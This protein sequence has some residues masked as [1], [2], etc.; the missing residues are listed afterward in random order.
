MAKWRTSASASYAAPRHGFPLLLISR[1]W[2]YIRHIQFTIQLFLTVSTF[3]P[4]WQSPGIGY[5]SVAADDALSPICEYIKVAVEVNGMDSMLTLPGETPREYLEYGQ[6]M[7]TRVQIGGEG[8]MVGRTALD[9]LTGDFLESHGLQGESSE[10]RKE[11]IASVLGCYAQ[12]PACHGPFALSEDYGRIDSADT[13]VADVQIGNKCFAG[14]KV[15][16]GGNYTETALDFV[17]R[18]GWNSGAG[19]RDALCVAN[20]IACSVHSAERQQREDLVKKSDLVTSDSGHRRK[21]E[22]ID[23][24][25]TYTSLCEGQHC[26]IRRVCWTGSE[27]LMKLDELHEAPMKK[28]W[29]TNLLKHPGLGG[30]AIATYK[31]TGLVE[32]ELRARR[33]ETL[34]W[35]KPPIVESRTEIIFQTHV[36]TTPLLPNCLRLLCPSLTH[37]SLFFFGMNPRFHMSQRIFSLYSV[38]LI[39]ATRQLL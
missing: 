16:R 19:C 27:W 4:G 6:K 31:Y 13:I 36:I 33:L 2:K 29:Q 9:K 8:Q 1:D 5:R 30:A 28:W 35:D 23:L 24:A 15:P 11:L 34:F 20:R 38:D 39:S 37:R 32:A 17:V 12:A 7:L 22:N 3:Q 21:D 26:R 25:G 14:L 10:R 18:Q